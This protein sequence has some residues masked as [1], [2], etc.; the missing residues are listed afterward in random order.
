T[1][2]MS[3]KVFVLGNPS[4]KLNDGKVAS[5]WSGYGTKTLVFKYNVGAESTADLRVTGIN[6]GSSIEDAAG[7]SLSSTLASDLKLAINTDSWK[8]AIS[9]N[10][11]VAANWMPGNVP[12]G[13]H[14]ASIGVAGTYTV[15]SSLSETVAALN[16]SNTSATLAVTGGTFTATNGTGVDAN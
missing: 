8:Q 16:I 2:G 4:M 11:A 14:E 15:T 7:N 12:N 10:F 1:L 9:G 6:Q 13:N 3:E 5:Y